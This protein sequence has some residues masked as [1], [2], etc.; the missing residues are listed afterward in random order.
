M[1]PHFVL[2][3]LMRKELM[4]FHGT[5]RPNMDSRRFY[6]RKHLLELKLNNQN[7]F[8][9]ISKKFT[10]KTFLARQN[11]TYSSSMSLEVY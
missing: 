8:Y 11:S 4:D 3:I 7:E 9:L 2:E 10:K 1:D 5:S 6:I